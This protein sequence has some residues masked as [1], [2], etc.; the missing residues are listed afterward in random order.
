MAKHKAH[1][2]ER[3]AGEKKSPPVHPG[4]VIRLALEALDP[5]HSVNQAALA[6]GWTRAGL[7]LLLNGDRGVT[8]ESALRLATY[9]GNGEQ[10]AELF[11]AMQAEY[12]LYHE[13]RRLRS[14]LAK[15]KPAKRRD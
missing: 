4:Q 12:D 3:V 1:E 10:G 6:I 13:R 9:L 11:M 15:I 7:G 8:P 14:Q 2:P 5:P